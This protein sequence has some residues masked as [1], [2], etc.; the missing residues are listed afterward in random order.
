MDANH[1]RAVLDYDPKAGVMTWIAPSKHH[2][3]LTGTEAGTSQR[4]QTGKAYWKIAINGRKFGRSRLAFAWMTG[5]WPPHMVDHI[6]GN[7][8]NDAWANLRHATVLENAWNHQRRAKKSSLPMGVR[9]TAAGR[10]A[11]RLAVNKVMLH[12]G[13]FDSPEA[14][15]AAYRQARKVH[16][17]DFA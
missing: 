6:D 1:I 16:Y 15:E 4:G 5:E 13:A 8:L 3:R 2:N 17:G 12:L 10:Y 7:S 9:T 14:A 11:A